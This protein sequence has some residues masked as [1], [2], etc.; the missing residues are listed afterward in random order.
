MSMSITEIESAVE[1]LPPD[2]F[3]E[4]SEWFEKFEAE[5]WE[6]QIEDDLEN[7][8][9]QALIQEAEIDFTEKNYKP[10]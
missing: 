8:K 10:L 7:G 3:A 6:K 4:F 5:V 2:K 1:K 9:L